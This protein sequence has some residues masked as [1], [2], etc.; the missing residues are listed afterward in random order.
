MILSTHQHMDRQYR[1]MRIVDGKIFPHLSNQEEL[2]IPTNGSGTLFSICPYVGG[3][4]YH[5]KFWKYIVFTRSSTEYIGRDPHHLVP[6]ELGG[7]Q[8][9]RWLVGRYCRYTTR[10]KFSEVIIVRADNDLVT[11]LDMQYDDLTIAGAKKYHS[12]ELKSWIAEHNDE[13]CP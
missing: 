10:G 2:N 11:L 12:A 1:C 3:T 6:E 13:Y 5:P 8:P 4:L 7:E 9:W